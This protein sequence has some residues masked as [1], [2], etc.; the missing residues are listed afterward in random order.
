MKNLKAYR[1]LLQVIAF[2]RDKQ[3]VHILIPSWDSKKLVK[4]PLTSFP[5]KYRN[6]SIIDLKFF[7][8]IDIGN[9]NTPE[10]FEF[11]EECK[12]PIGKWA[13]LLNHRNYYQI[14]K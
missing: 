11:I 8:M 4:I 5:E 10:I 14:T 12:P 6:S 9:E 13:A 2:S 7:A 1:S 3:S